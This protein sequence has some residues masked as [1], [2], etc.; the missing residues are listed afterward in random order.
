[1]NTDGHGY[2]A[3]A[4]KLRFTLKVNKKS[5]YQSV[6]IRITI[7]GNFVFPRKLFEPRM[8][9][10]SHGLQL[11]MILPRHTRHFYFSPWR[12]PPFAFEKIR[13]YL[14]PSVVGIPLVAARGR[15]VCIRGWN[16]L[17]GFNC[18]IQVENSCRAGNTGVASPHPHREK[19]L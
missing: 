1:M 7:R 16:S 14:F 15:A 2:Q 10:D 13:V 12:V 17:P 4:E 5:G 9:T 18:G 6:F 3:L 8:N 19:W 11:K